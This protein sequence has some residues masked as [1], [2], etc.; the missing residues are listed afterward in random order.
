MSRTLYVKE[1]HVACKPSFGHPCDIK[2]IC[3]RKWLL[4]T[5]HLIKSTSKFS[6][7]VE[8]LQIILLFLYITGQ[9]RCGWTCLPPPFFNSSIGGPQLGLQL[10]WRSIS[11]YSLHHS[12]NK[13][14][15]HEAISP[16]SDAAMVLTGDSLL[17]EPFL[18]EPQC[19][20]K[21]LKCPPTHTLQSWSGPGTTILWVKR[22]H[23]CRC[24]PPDDK[25]RLILIVV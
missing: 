16:G 7:K 19:K 22:V 10:K 2:N 20:R 6:R 24:L 5:L 14:Y 17:G 9:T 1:L 4:P 3:Y 15:S 18:L 11:S 13:I 12:P 21:G 8:S 23:A 25:R